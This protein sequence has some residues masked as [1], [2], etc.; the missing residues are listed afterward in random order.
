[1]VK[2][3]GTEIVERIDACLKSKGQKRPE[4]CKAI[5][6]PTANISAWNTR[7]SIPPA[8]VLLDIADYLEV[9]IEYL[10][11]GKDSYLSRSREIQQGKILENQ[12][13]LTQQ[14][15]EL[16]NQLPDNEKYIILSLL[17]CLAKNTSK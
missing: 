17:D 11:T 9:P 5:N 8:D 13:K 6:Y 16:F 12:N 3:N 4:M 14:C 2:T 15:I 10:I 1:M 7:G